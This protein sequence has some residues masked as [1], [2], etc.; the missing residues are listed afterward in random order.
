MY[1][2]LGCFDYGQ[3]HVFPD[4]VAN[5][6]RQ[7]FWQGERQERAGG[8]QLWHGVLGELPDRNGVGPHGDARPKLRL[9]GLDWRLSGHWTLHC[10]PDQ[11]HYGP[12]HFCQRKQE[13]KPDTPRTG[14]SF[15]S[16]MGAR[17]FLAILD[18]IRTRSVIWPHSSLVENPSIP[19][20]SET[21]DPGR[22][23]EFR[24]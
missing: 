15:V 24:S 12:R 23:R 19:S 6:H 20:T 2:D 18:W 10:D 11:P 3:S 9:H 21:S 1:G 5:P 17:M 4:H 14:D 22:V 13:V 8:D 7:Y 16:P